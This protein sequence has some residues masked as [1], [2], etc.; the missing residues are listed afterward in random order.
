MIYL[1]Y[2]IEDYI[3]E[4]QIEKI[5]TKTKIDNY[6]TVYYDLEQTKIE[7]IID[8]ANTASLF[9]DKK[10]IIIE[11]SYIFTGQKGVEQNLLIL[12]KYLNSPNLN[13]ILIFTV[14]TEKL[15]ERKKIV[16]LIKQKGSV[17]ECSNKNINKTVKEMFED[18]EIS[19]SLIN[20]L[21]DRVGSNLYILKQEVD[22]I[23]LYKDSNKTITK[24]DIINLTSKNVS[25]DIFKLIEAIVLK[26]KDEAMQIYKAMLKINE[27][28]IKIIIMLANQFRIIYQT[29]NLYIK[30]YTEKDI[31]NILQIHPYRIKL[32]LEKGKVFKSEDLLKYLNLLADMDSD[33]KSGLIDKNIALELF[34]LNL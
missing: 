3:I 31:T 20:T 2:G 16:K 7:D 23:K 21:I 34:I 18:Y 30:G 33:I 14:K 17:L 32:A 6:A 5:T 15:D 22:K 13:T 10:I 4:Q 27:E 29:K 9:D 8:N 26:N 1:F 19:D 25:T 11:N 28:P 12:E 24:D